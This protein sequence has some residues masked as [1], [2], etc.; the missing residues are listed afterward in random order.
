MG[1][2]IHMMVE[3][4]KTI[5]NDEKWV[6]YDHF[7]KNPYFGVFD[8]E[9]ELERVDLYSSRNYVT[10]SQLCGVRS[11]FDDSPR[12]SNPRGV[13]S[14]SCNYISDE[15]KK[16]DGDGHSHSFATLAEI[17]AF[18]ANLAPTKFKGMISQQ[19]ARE[20]DNEGKKPESWCGWT[21]NDSYVHRE[22]EDVV[23][24]LKPIE[25][26]LEKRALENWWH[27]DSIQAENIRIV[28]FFDN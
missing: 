23:D 7:R 20:L 15:V 22:W 25:D 6:S 10:F 26:A 1:C 9:D 21:S 3:V 18:R 11:Y 27:K 14:D 28:F 17:I 12:I 5:N 8:D 16:W 19:Q 13:P 24:A 2:D 4:K